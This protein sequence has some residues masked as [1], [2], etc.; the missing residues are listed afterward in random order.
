MDRKEQKKEKKWDIYQVLG[1]L[2]GLLLIVALSIVFYQEYERFRAQQQLKAL[3]EAANSAEETEQSMD[4][5]PDPNDILTQR[6][7]EIPQKDLDWEELQKENKDI[8]AWIYIPGT[9]VDYPVLQHSTER[10]YYLNHNLDGSEGYPGCIYTQNLN[11]KDFTDYNTI[12]YGHNMKDGSMFQ[13][14]HKYRDPEFFDEN[15]L[16]FI[17]LPDEVLVYEL[18]AAYEYG[19]QHLL[20]QYNFNSTRDR[21]SYLEDLSQI[22]SMSANFREDI[23]VTEENHIITMS[24]CVGGKPDKRYLVQ[25]VLVNDPA[26]AEE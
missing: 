8:Y 2:F 10:S 4:E 15:R 5:K 11:R 12:V 21:A 19:D 16:V 17:Y 22:R 24:T 20:F 3:Q 1:V 14:L 7:I 9:K 26:L 6:G 25:G 18:F 13:T 23:T